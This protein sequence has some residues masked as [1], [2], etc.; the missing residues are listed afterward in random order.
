MISM[1]ERQKFYSFL[2]AFFGGIIVIAW[3]AP[4]AF[5][6]LTLAFALAY[7]LDPAVDWLEHRKVPRVAST[8]IILL[9]A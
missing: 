5:K 7:L 4:G 2:A 9:L 3:L 8:L 1:D 6:S